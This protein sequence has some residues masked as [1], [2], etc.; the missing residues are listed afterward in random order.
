MLTVLQAQGFE[1]DWPE[2]AS[3]AKVAVRRWLTLFCNMR[4]EIEW[5]ATEAGR[6]ESVQGR[7]GEAGCL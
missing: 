3:V 2:G 1:P 5:T 6:I 7:F 4:A